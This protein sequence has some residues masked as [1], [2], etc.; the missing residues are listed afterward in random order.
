MLRN[1]LI[2]TLRTLRR[3]K[4]NTII[5]V[6]GLALSMACCIVVY[7][8]MQHQHSFDSFHTNAERIY[9]V[10]SQYQG[11]K[12][13]SYQGS[14]AYPVPSALRNDF[15]T[16]P[17]VTQVV[18]YHEA[19]VQSSDGAEAIKVDYLHDYGL[20]YADEYFLQMFDYPL[21]AGQREGLLTSPDEVVLT[22]A[23]ADRLYGNGYRGRYDELL[24]KTLLVNKNSYQVTGVLPDIPRNANVVF[25][26]MLST[27]VYEHNNN[28]VVDNWRDYHSDWYTF[29]MLSEAADVAQQEAQ[30]V[31][32]KDKYLDEEQAAKR[33]YHLQALPEVHTDERYGGTMYAAP[34]ILMD[35][36]AI[37]GIIVLL[38]ACINFVNLSTA[39]SLKRAKEIGIRK[40]L[41]GL[42]GQLMFQFMS[43][44]FLQTI[45]AAGLAL[46]IAVWFVEVYNQYVSPVIDFGLTIEGDVGYFLL[47]L[48]IMVTLLAGYYPARVLAGFRPVDALKQSLSRKQTGFAGKFSLRKAL[49][50][51]QFIISQL[52]IIGTI[53]I[54]VQMHYIRTQDL[55][56]NQNNIAVVFVPNNDLAKLTAFRNH[57][58]N[59]S[60]VEHVSFGSGPPLSSAQQWT[61]VHNSLQGNMEKYRIEQKNIDPEYLSTF[62]IPLV[63][64]RNLREEDQVA[65]SDSVREYNALFNE[66]AIKAFGFVRPEEAINQVVITDADQQVRIVGVVRDFNNA[67]LQRNIHPCMLIYG[68]WINL[69]AM[70]FSGARSP[71][72]LAFVKEAWQQTYPD[73]YYEIQSLSEYFEL[74]AMYIIEDVMYQAFKIFAFLSIMVGCLGLYGLVSYLSLQ[75]QKE[76]SVRKVLG[77]SAWQIVYLFSREFTILVILA[78]AIAAPVGYLAMRAW[79]DTFAYRINLSLL[80]FG[81]A[82]LASITTAWI[83]ISYKSIQAALANPTEALRG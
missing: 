75:R 6:M 26:L 29:A 38:T 12:G 49:V 56:F 69:V 24:G 37:M 39:Q 5:N 47:A 19:V 48:C 60:S 36:F 27:Q 28:W 58:V 22:Q 20:L 17:L 33:T 67:P 73:E 40:A 70:Q 9:R 13:I 78:F 82:L 41:G 7:A 71:H 72:E 44:V 1:Y 21:L 2:T 32:F 50:V 8:F 3:N 59:Q 35:A 83:I 43:E 61:Q 25:G 62:G 64:G 81:L 45:L 77:A 18:A 54:A 4:L 76:I 16:F 52:L 66:Q 80:Y 10:V 34:S 53:V 14:V 30:L 57:L 11:N 46:V 63:A 23:V 65:F 74:S 15:P 55:G 68:D 51:T 42:K 79:L 31:M